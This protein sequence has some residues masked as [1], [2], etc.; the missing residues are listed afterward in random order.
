MKTE[1]SGFSSLAASVPTWPQQMVRSHMDAI[2][3][4]KV[5]K[6]VEFA[7]CCKSQEESHQC[8]IHT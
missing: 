3:T 8:E 6:S 1:L 2:A 5:C 7:S 4:G